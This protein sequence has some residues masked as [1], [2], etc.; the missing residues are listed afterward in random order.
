MAVVLSGRACRPSSARSSPSDIPRLQHKTGGDT[1]ALLSKRGA[2]S[3]RCIALNRKLPEGVLVEGDSD[4]VEAYIRRIQ[5]R[6]DQAT[7]VTDLAAGKLFNAAGIAAGAA[8]IAANSAKFVRLSPDSVKA[9]AVAKRIPGTNGYFRMMTRGADGK[10]LGQ[11]QWKPT[12]IN[13]QRLMSIQMIAV[14]MHSRRRLRKLKI[15][16]DVSKAR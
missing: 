3:G 7:V 14:Q 8:T 13:P 1:R 10:F 16:S 15:R 12:S 9:L 2:L 6:S 4:D 11:L 5:E